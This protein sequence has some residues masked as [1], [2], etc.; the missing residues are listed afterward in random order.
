MKL[1]FYIL[2]AMSQIATGQDSLSYRSHIRADQIE[3]IKEDSLINVTYDFMR[4]YLWL[5]YPEGYLELYKNIIIPDSVVFGHRIGDG[6]IKFGQNQWNKGFLKGY[7]EGQNNISGGYALKYITYGA[8][9]AG[10]TIFLIDMLKSER[11]R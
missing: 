11:K 4:L 3:M 10:V 2:L 8:V 1:W 6:V 5:Y 7:K 9:I